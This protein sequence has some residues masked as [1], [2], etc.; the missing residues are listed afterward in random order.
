MMRTILKGIQSSVYFSVF[1]FPLVMLLTT[2]IP[3]FN[4][5][6]YTAHN[7]LGFLL[8]PLCTPYIMVRL[9]KVVLRSS[10][11]IE[12]M[13]V[14]L[15]LY[16]SF[17]LVSYPLI[18]F[19]DY[20]LSWWPGTSIREDLCHALLTFPITLLFSHDRQVLTSFAFGS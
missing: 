12:S 2:T 11:K 4:A 8:L 15:G 17:Y 16:F 7:S 5:F 14:G 13:L 6:L 19:G 10:N 18:S 9:A 20:L 1:A 3:I